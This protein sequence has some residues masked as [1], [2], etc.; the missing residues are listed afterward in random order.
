MNWTEAVE[1]TE[2]AELAGGADAAEAGELA[3][4]HT[5][6]VEASDHTFMVEAAAL[7]TAHVC[8]WV[9]GVECL[10]PTQVLHG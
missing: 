6:W 5:F 3:G 4:G 7:P 2:A 1:W 8:F 9:Y 10:L